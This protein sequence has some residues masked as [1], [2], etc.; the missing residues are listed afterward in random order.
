MN[1][2]QSRPSADNPGTRVGRFAPSP[3]G[4]LHLGSLYS[5]LISWLDVRASG[6]IWLLRIEDIDPP[7]EVPG[8][9]DAICRTLEQHGLYWDG[10]IMWQ[11]R[12]H[13]AYAQTLERLRQLGLAFLCDCSRS[14]LHSR[15]GIYPGTCRQRLLPRDWQQQTLPDVAIRLRVADRVISFH[16]R[17]RGHCH[18]HLTHD[19]GDFIVR[20]RDGC[21]AYQLAV[22]VDD[23]EQ[24][25]THVVRGLDLLDS[26]PW[27]IWLQQQ[28][29]LPQ[30]DYLHTA[31]LCQASGQK[32]SK[33]ACAAALAADDAPGNLARA[34]HLLGLPGDP[35][36]PVQTQLA[37]ALASYE[38]QQ[39]P[40][41][42]T[43]VDS[44]LVA[45]QPRI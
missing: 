34:L 1:P 42:N 39:L 37:Q 10:E 6:G 43:T 8:A 20:R 14:Q 16:D 35:Q 31:L 28:L 18:Y 9:G 21:W 32:L 7:R 22:V 41:A 4:P 27:Q 3:S 24:G 2:P 33:Q 26:T 15:G 12:R 38:S 11:S 29:G 44:A 5:A 36:A 25:I 13:E 30:P 40:L 17:L 23:A 19:L 45:A